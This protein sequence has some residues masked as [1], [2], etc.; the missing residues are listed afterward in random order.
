MACHARTIKS[1]PKIRCC[2][3]C[4]IPIWLGKKGGALQEL[5]PE[6]CGPWDWEMTSTALRSTLSRPACISRLVRQREQFTGQSRYQAF[7]YHSLEQ[8]MILF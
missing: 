4:A 3:V 1:F 2:P 8:N 7:L 6:V 5:C